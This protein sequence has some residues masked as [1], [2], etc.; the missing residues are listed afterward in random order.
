MYT[1]K[2]RDA[3]S[4]RERLRQILGDALLRFN[5]Y[6]ISDEKLMAGL[7]KMRWRNAMSL[8]QAVILTFVGISTE[9]EGIMAKEWVTYRVGD[10]EEEVSESMAS[11]TGRST[12]CD[13]LRQ[14]RHTIGGYPVRYGRQI[15]ALIGKRVFV[16]RNI[17]TSKGRGYGKAMSM[18]RL[19]G[20]LEEDAAIVREAMIAAKQEMLTRLLEYPACSFYLDGTP[21]APVDITTPIRRLLDEISQFR[22][23]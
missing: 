15:K 20:V 14:V 5:P 9:G 17:I 6:A 3:A 2:I 13:S 18:H 11:L 8:T 22:N 1:L 7:E 21:S 19:K 4:Y 16:S 10:S 12:A 23:S